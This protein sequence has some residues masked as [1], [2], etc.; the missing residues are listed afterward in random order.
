M[1]SPCLVELEGFL[2]FNQVKKELGQDQCMGRTC[3]SHDS[4]YIIRKRIENSAGLYEITDKIFKW[5]EKIQQV[6]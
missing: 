6:H 5:E 4:N 2:T 1:F 3:I